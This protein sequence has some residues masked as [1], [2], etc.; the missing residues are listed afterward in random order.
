[1]RNLILKIQQRQVGEDEQAKTLCYCVC[2]RALQM[3]WHKYPLRAKFLLLHKIPKVRALCTSTIAR[4]A[5]PMGLIEID[6][7][8]EK[9]TLFELIELLLY[10]NILICSKMSERKKHYVVVSLTIYDIL[11]VSFCL[12]QIIPYILFSWM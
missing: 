2:T 8:F 7:L 6:G 10:T 9:Q 12:G 1:M 11:K 4:D 3:Q 5:L